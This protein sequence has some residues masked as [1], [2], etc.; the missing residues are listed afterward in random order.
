M[1]SRAGGWAAQ[2]LSG[3]QTLRKAGVDNPHAEAFRL[4]L[5]AL[6]LSQARYWHNPPPATPAAVDRF[7]HLLRRRAQREPFAYLCGEKEFMGL[8]LQ[9]SPRVLI[10]RPETEGLVETVLRRAPAAVPLTVWD[11]GTGSGAVA[12]AL[13]RLGPPVWRVVGVDISPDALAVANANGERLGLDVEWRQSDL[14]GALDGP[15]DV[16]AA[17]L[18]YIDRIDEG[19]DPELAFEPDI[20]LFADHGGLALIE[21]LIAETSSR[22]APGGLIAL[23]IGAGQADAVETQLG[24]AGFDDVERDRDLSGW[25]RVVS[26]RFRGKGEQRVGADF[27]RGAQPPAAGQGSG[28]RD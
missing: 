13:R 23:E 16:V 4:L 5:L 1:E 3:T 24:A 9:V 7:W 17:N 25:I 14:L 12:L 18:P 20:A 8:L 2:L 28:H 26:A 15:V 10:P 27:G 22:M 6:G 11:V 19:R 21:R